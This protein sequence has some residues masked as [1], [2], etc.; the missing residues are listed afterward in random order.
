MPKYKLRGEVVKRWEKAGCP[1]WNYETTKKI[2]LEVDHYLAELGQ[3]P[4]PRFV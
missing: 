2:C 1:Q 4:A 3:N